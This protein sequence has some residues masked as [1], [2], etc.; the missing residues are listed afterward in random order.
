MADR[1]EIPDTPGL[2]WRARKNGWEALWRARTDLVRQGW[3]PK[4]VRLWAGSEAD[5]GEIERDWI[6]DRCKAIQ[7]EMLLWARGGAPKLAPAFDGKL[8]S[9][10]ACYTSD[11]DSTYHKLRYQTRVNYDYLIRRVIADVWTVDGEVRVIGEETIADIKART[12]LRWYELWSDDGA[13]IAM[14]RALVRMLR[15]LFSFGATILEDAECA[16]ICGVM[17]QMRFKMSKPRDQ[18]ITSDQAAA[19]IAE[20][21]RRGAHSIALAQAF[22][23]ECTLRQKDVIGEWVPIGERGTSDLVIGNEKWLWGLRWSEIDGNLSLMH[24]TSKRQKEIIVDLR[25][26]PM[27]MVEL[28]RL[29]ARPAAGPIVVC[30]RRQRPYRA[31][32]FRQEWREIA[33]AVGIPDDVRNMDTRA[34]AIS[35][36]T[37]SGATL[38]D[39]RHAATH[40]NISMT[41]RYSRGSE[42]KTAT[43]MRLRAEHRNK[44]RTSGGNEG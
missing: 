26:A 27:V 32:E 6:S 28:Q 11:S 44:P 7:G 4:N 8:R 41:Q 43:V 21:H 39:V 22:Q 33:R 42:K 30:E 10:V 29:G 38:E 1:P 16:R 9:L 2:T 40:S 17:Q 19:V 14:G 3:T 37:D 15:T 5:L 25:L 20:A 13:K 31:Y 36:A 12:M 34:G 24:T 23:F 35:E 18:Q